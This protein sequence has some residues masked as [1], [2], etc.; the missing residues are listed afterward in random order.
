[1]G[2]LDRDLSADDL[3]TIEPS[4]IIASRVFKIAEEHDQIRG[5]VDEP[6]TNDL[7]DEA[8]AS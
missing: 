6:A 1:M 2:D 8:K 7:V 3:M 4:D 5:Q